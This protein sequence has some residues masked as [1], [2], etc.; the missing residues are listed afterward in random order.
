MQLVLFRCANGVVAWRRA[1]A[2]G[3]GRAWICLNDKFH[4]QNSA[5]D[6]GVV[7]FIDAMTQHS[8]SVRGAVQQV[9]W[10]DV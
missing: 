10:V 6:T 2:V 8:V 3:L 1:K 4:L 7:A 9:L 5:D